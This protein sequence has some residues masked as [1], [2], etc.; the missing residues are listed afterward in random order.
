MLPELFKSLSLPNPIEVES[1]A[2]LI[3]LTQKVV[4]SGPSLCKGGTFKTL[5]LDC[6]KRL[7]YEMQLLTNED[8]SF[9]EDQSPYFI[10]ACERG[11]IAT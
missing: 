1:Q 6:A 3:L 2:K 10:F 9:I 8:L 7:V 5:T 11:G 4:L